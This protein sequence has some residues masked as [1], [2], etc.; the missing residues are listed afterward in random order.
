M[1][2]PLDPYFSHS[3]NSPGLLEYN[4][5]VSSNAGD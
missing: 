4:T 1:T 2:S 3:T 5:K